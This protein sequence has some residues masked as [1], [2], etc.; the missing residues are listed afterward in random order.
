ILLFLQHRS[1]YSFYGNPSIV[2][3]KKPSI[4]YSKTCVSIRSGH[5]RSEGTRGCT[6]DFFDSGGLFTPRCLQLLGLL[7]TPHEQC[8]PLRKLSRGHAVGQAPFP[9]V[10]GEERCGHRHVVEGLHGRLEHRTTR[11]ARAA[12]H[13]QVETQVP[14]LGNER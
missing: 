4:V 13:D 5:G 9:A 12:G 2:V 10:T 14:P 3:E 1:T 6:V 7:S 8:P 11:A